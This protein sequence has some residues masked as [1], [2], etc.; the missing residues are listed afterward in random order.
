MKMTD[1]RHFTRLS[2]EI[3]RKIKKGDS[4]ELLTYKKDRKI[5]I[6]KVDEHNFD[7]VEDGFEG[8]EYTAVA[9]SKLAK[10]LRQLQ[11]I[12]FPR[13]NTFFMDIIPALE[14]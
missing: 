6:I 11:R 8:K 10:L 12:E 4:I 9:D 1:I 13:S 2:L 3:L 7:V 14:N 5:R